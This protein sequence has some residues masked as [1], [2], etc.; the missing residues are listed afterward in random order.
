MRYFI[1]FLT[2]S[3]IACSGSGEAAA[4]TAI[5][6]VQGT[7][8]SSPL[9]GQEVV[10]EGIVS[11]DFQA[12]DADEMSN[13]GGFYVQSAPDNDPATSDGVF[14][15][16]GDTPAVDVN[17]GDRVRVAGSVKEYFGETQI[18]ASTVAVIGND[19]IQPTDVILPVAATIT[20]SDGFLIADLERYEGMLVR[21]PQTLTVSQTR[22]LD[23]FGQMLLSAG[24]RQFAFTNQQ[25]PNVTAYRTHLE[26]IAAR[27][28]ILDDGMHSSNSVPIRYL[29]AGNIPNDTLR[30]G[31]EISGV[32]GVL[33]FS[34]GS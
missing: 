30:I 7:G 25:A 5:Y 32:T 22:Q 31:D 2:S 17:P 6:D 34:R 11:G 33:R 13:L 4:D 9:D 26:A 8:A 12:G 18:V 21:F 20:N 27:R 28:I 1:L 19:T 10:V 24:G 16:D 29:T 14:V 3:L 15:F 23:R